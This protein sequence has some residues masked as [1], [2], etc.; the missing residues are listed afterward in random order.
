[1]RFIDI[2][3]LKIPNEWLTD[4]NLLTDKLRTIPEDERSTFINSKNNLW[5]S[6]KPIMEELSHGKCWYCEI[7]NTRS[8]HHVDH[9]R[10]KNRITLDDGATDAGYWWLSFDF[11]NFRIA[12]SY[13]NCLHTG[14]DGVVRGKA[15]KFPL[16]EGSEKAKE[17]TYP[18]DERPALLDP[19]DP[20]DSSLLTFIEDGAAYSK[21]PVEEHEEYQRASITIEILNLNERKIR[22]ARRQLKE[23]CIRLLDRGDKAFLVYQ[24]GS[25]VGKEQ[26]RQ[27][28]FEINEKIRENAELSSVARA[29]ILNSGT[30]WVSIYL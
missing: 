13:C 19:C 18:I 30:P 20:L 24:Q 12:C 10:P 28:I 6:I 14:E 15:D 25:I 5:K 7:K 3:E 29:Y 2:R 16:L 26:F 8:D 17:W 9:H 4:A 22:E 1:M 27:V 23:E 21:N 11:R